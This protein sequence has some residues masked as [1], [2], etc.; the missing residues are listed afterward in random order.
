VFLKL[1]SELEDEV[2]NSDQDVTEQMNELKTLLNIQARAWSVG[3]R[4]VVCCS[5]VVWSVPVRAASSGCRGFQW[6][7]ALALLA[8]AAA[9]C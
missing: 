9:P 1:W 8:F 7:V 5:R 3:C 2:K 4:C 6:L